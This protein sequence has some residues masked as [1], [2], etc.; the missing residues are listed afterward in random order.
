MA[1]YALCRGQSPLR[2]LFLALALAAVL[3]HTGCAATAPGEKKGETPPAIADRLPTAQAYRSDHHVIHKLRTNDT[4]ELLARVY[5]GDP[6]RAWVIEEANPHTPFVAGQ[7]IVIPLKKRAFGGL[8]PNGYQLVPVLCY[9]RFA[10]HCKSRLCMPASIFRAQ[11]DYLKQNG[12]RTIG[13]ADLE[14][15]LNFRGAVPEKAVVITIDDG[16]RSGYDVAYPLL[17]QYGFKAIFFVY[18]DFVGATASAVTWEMLRE[19]QANGFDIGSHTLSHCDLTKPKQGETPDAFHRRIEGEI[20]E[21]KRV[22]DAKLAGE[23]IA[24][25]YPYGEFNPTVLQMTARAGYRLA[26]TARR[27]GNAFF[28]DPLALERDQILSQDMDKFAASLKTIK[29]LKLE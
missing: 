24:L 12:Y 29:A 25:A 4:P 18:T 15:F 27:G 10:E 22:I 2:G 13:L 23:T 14:N 9:H 3:I 19:M 11:L 1:G 21:S 28:A 8:R 20:I 26:F 6:T 17:L 5:L 16:Y 7:M